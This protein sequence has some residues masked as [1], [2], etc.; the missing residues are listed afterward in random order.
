MLDWRRAYTDLFAALCVGEL[1]LVA[2]IFLLPAPAGLIVGWLGCGLLYWALF[3]QM[4]HDR[5]RN[6]TEGD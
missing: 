5:K 2:W 4:N 3:W 1:Q 6:H